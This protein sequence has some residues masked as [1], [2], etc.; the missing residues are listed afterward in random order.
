MSIQYKNFEIGISRLSDD[1]LRAQLSAGR[2][3]AA[4][5][6]IELNNAE[7]SLL[8]QGEL[9]AED[10]KLIEVRASSEKEQHKLRQERLG[11]RLY[12]A[13]FCAPSKQW[14][15]EDI[16]PGDTLHLRLAEARKATEESRTG[17]RLVFRIS[18]EALP[19]MP[20]ELLCC[21]H[22]MGIGSTGEFLAVDP[23]TPIVRAPPPLGGFG[24]VKIG[25]PL[26]LLVVL[27]RTSL[28]PDFVPEDQKED[29]EDM[30]GD[31]DHLAVDYVGTEGDPKAT[32]DV[33]RTRLN[34]TEVPKREGFPDYYSI[35]HF[36]GHGEFR[37]DLHPPQGFVILEDDGEDHPVPGYELANAIRVARNTK[38]GVTMVILQSCET[39]AT[40]L[41]EF[42]GVAQQLIETVPCVV[43]M[44]YSV[45]A[46][47]VARFVGLLYE[48]WLRKRQPLELAVTSAR[49]QLRQDFLH[50]KDQDP[51]DWVAPVLFQKS[52]I[53]VVWNAPELPPEKRKEAERLRIQI[54]GDEE[55]IRELERKLQLSLKPEIEQKLETAKGYLEDQKKS[56]E[57]ELGQ[58]LGTYLDLG[59]VVA[60]LGDEGVS[61]P[62]HLH[63]HAHS[64]TSVTFV[65][66]FD[67]TQVEFKDVEE[68]PGNLAAASSKE[69][70]NQRKI[71]IKGVEGEI[72]RGGKGEIATLLFGL[73]P[74]AETTKLTAEKVRINEGEKWVS[75]QSSPGWVIVS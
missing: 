73:K 15:D 51:R 63:S 60:A 5:D 30:L 13:I 38:V 18:E 16:L 43:A 7:L 49:N 2:S 23:S 48:H 45:T 6:H 27:C 53:E 71:V 52:E 41:N 64:P 72:K 12:K 11:K 66:K 14:K 10:H 34:G 25:F 55:K 67:S 68:K 40:S 35:F 3:A 46:E 54:E 33:V 37:A 20:V 69:G 28:S 21:R 39:A 70:A 61:V 32:W 62:V 17:L 1:L 65:V 75:Q 31:L 47:T 59:D 29:L 56:R 44:Q 58:L 22:G 8:S 36:I 9:P 42:R 50:E 19:N 24:R 4:L 57:D 74:L 26:R